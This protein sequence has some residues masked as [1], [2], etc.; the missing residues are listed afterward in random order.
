MPPEET[1]TAEPATE[2]AP[3]PEPAAETDPF[4]EGADT[5]GRDYVE[6]LRQEN[7]RRRTAL[8]PYEETFSNLE[9][10]ERDYLLGINKALVHDPVTAL[11][12]LEKL[13]N[14]IRAAYPDDFA[15]EPA[16]VPA[17][18]EPAPEPSADDDKPL[19]RAELAQLLEERER[20]ALE[21]QQRAAQDA[22]IDNLF[23]EAQ[24]LSE[25]YTEGSLASQELFYLAGTDPEI[26]GDLAKAHAKRMEQRKALQDAAVREYVESLRNGG[27]VAHPPSTPAAGGGD[28]PPH[29]TPTNLKEA[30]E[31]ANAR[32]DAVYGPQTR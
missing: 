23:V 17:T 24:Q 22:E 29:K 19:T 10:D 28:A 14:Q 25:E 32:L 15:E 11:P 27:A 6:K 26:N 9:Q 8:Q 20:Q 12:E 5:F 16:P 31:A 13:A 3:A 21:Q 7:A 1:P 2:P 30:A 4:D 18:A